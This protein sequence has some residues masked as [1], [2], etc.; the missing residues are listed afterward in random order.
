MPTYDYYCRKCDCLVE[1]FHM[2]SDESKRR[3]SECK[4]IMQKQ[5][6]CGY[7]VSKGLKPT[8]EDTRENEHQ[9]KVT[10]KE[11]AYKMRRKAFGSDVKVPI[12]KADP[13]H[14]VKKGRTLGGQQM[15]IDKQEFI[16][17]AAQS[18]YIVDVAKKALKPK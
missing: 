15:N 10:D 4:S 13:K 6:G 2:M 9:K 8:M 5:L 11:R 12:E 7:L 3:C 17:S 14:V 18:D 1:I 16:K